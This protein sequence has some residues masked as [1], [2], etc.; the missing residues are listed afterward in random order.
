MSV[1]QVEDSD[2]RVHAIEDG[3]LPLHLDREDAAPTSSFVLLCTGSSSWGL[4]PDVLIRRLR[5]L[6]VVE[7]QPIGA[8]NFIMRSLAA[9]LARLLG[10]LLVR[11][12]RLLVS[13]A[14]T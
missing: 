5:S 10:C 4:R 9:V 13:V 1:V 7:T 8:R 11:M 6:G 12:S 2:K 14:R 3:L